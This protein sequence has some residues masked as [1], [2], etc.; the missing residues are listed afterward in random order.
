MAEQIKQG[1]APAAASPWPIALAGLVALA[2]AM[3]LG[4]F[5]FTPLLPMML[6]DGV[7]D[8][9][10]ASWLASANYFGY[11]L[12][13]ML[14]TLQPW[15][16]ARFRGLPLLAYSS[17]VR[18]GLL[19]TGLLTLAMAW[20]MPAAWPWLRFAA[21]V[22]SAVVFVFT[23][24]WCLSRLARLGFPALGGVIYAG[25]GAGIVVSGLFASGMV[26]WG[27]RAA[28][29]WLIFGVLAFALT[30][31]VWHS[32]RG[33]DERL[34][35]R[36]A[37]LVRPAGAAPQPHGHAEM[38]LLTL[39][40]GL[41][42][43]GYIITATFL[44]V[45]ARAAL[46]GSAWLDLFWPIFGLGVM[47]GALLAT[48]ISPNKDFRVLLAVCYFV[49]ALG[50]SASLWSPSLAGFALGSLLLGLPFTAITFF[51]M[52]EVRRLRPHTAASF[53]GLLTATYGVGQ[54]LGPPLAA[55]LLLRAPSADAGF[56]LSLEIAASALLVGAALY[57]WLAR[58]YPVAKKLSR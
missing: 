1:L 45:I 34:A 31:L 32:L 38:A 4:R 33:G 53:M 58:V 11:L 10:A 20:Q 12:G 3:G 15:L 36:A 43:F 13:A 40:Y 49:Q 8:L 21:G 51:A 54:I 30:A 16:W 39:A 29:G 50:I 41:A 52:Q 14:C 5:A 26:A 6:N 19:A 7:L 25:P 23:S 46:P 42:G 47:A 2:V 27:W 24:G 37:P 28:T 48:R 35:P 57:G 17:L 56:S 9:P 18:A 44:P 55:L 22:A